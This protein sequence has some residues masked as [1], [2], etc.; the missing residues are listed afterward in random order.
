MLVG[1]RLFSTFLFSSHFST[2]SLYLISHSFHRGVF[3]FAVCL[4]LLPFVFSCDDDDSCHQVILPCYSSLQWIE[5]NDF[6]NCCEVYRSHCRRCT[7]WLWY[8]YTMI[9]MRLPTTSALDNFNNI[10][11]NR[12]KTFGLISIVIGRLK[13]S[14]S[15]FFTYLD[16]QTMCWKFESVFRVCSVGLALNVCIFCVCSAICSLRFLPL[17]MFLFTRFSANIPVQNKSSKLVNT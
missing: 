10:Q 7:Q 8:P 3:P 12:C 2:I 16:V 4:Y 1:V 9:T 14:T 15:F 6:L 13:F 5:Y 17:N 11:S